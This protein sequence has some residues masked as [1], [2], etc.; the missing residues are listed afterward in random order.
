MAVK[1]F[2]SSCVIRMG[3]QDPATHT[4][5]FKVYIAIMIV[6]VSAKTLHV[7]VKILSK[8]EIS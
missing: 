7:S 8:F 3:I 6:T 2:N 5:I 4:H 1:S